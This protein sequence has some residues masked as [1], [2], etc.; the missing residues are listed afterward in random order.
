[1][2][3]GSR[4]QEARAAGAQAL[5]SE[6]PGEASDVSRDHIVQGLLELGRVFGFYPH[7]TGNKQRVSTRIVLW[8]DLRVDKPLS[9]CCVEGGR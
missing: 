6:L 4:S 3:W 2:I 1:M 8:S 9:G 7:E 5:V